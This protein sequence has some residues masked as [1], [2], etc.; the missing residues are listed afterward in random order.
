MSISS[1]QA[2]PNNKGSNWQAFGPG[3]LLASAAIGGS[4]LISSTQAGAL[5]GWQLAIMI[6]LANFFKYPF[7]KFGTDY[8]Y[9]TGESLIA[10]YAKKSRLYLWAFFILSLAASVISTGAVALLAAVILGFMLPE[11]WGL[12]NSTLAVIVMGISWFFLIVGH[13]KML[14]K[15]TKWIMVALTVTTLA[16]VIIAAGKPTAIA[17][18]FVPVSPWNLAN[19]AFIVA[20]M[21]WMPAPLEFSAINS[22]WISAKVKADNTTHRQGLIDFNVGFI[23]TA[24]LAL[25]FLALGL[26]VQYGSG[27]EIQTQG[28]AYVGQLINMY[29][30]TI[31]EWSRL[32]VAFIAFMVM[33]GTTITCADGYGRINAESWRL[34]KGDIEVSQKQILVWTTYSALGGYII[35]TFFTG[36]LGAMLKFAMITAFISAPIFGWLNYSLAKNDHQLSSGMKLYSIAGLIFLGGIALLFMAQL[37]GFLD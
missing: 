5:Y 21:G 35:I 34:I 14:D 30:A 4:H 20:L 37:V 31:G 24:L 16:A 7:F 25:V 23:V 32:L 1:T 15:L 9:D 26:F 27:V 29:T 2:G 8:V 12:S 3:I 11:S 28:G 33:F 17:P 6:I 19:L 18:N 22:M 36:Q 10:G 13:Y